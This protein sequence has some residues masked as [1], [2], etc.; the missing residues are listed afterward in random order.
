[1]SDTQKMDDFFLETR[2][3]I[4]Q[5]GEIALVLPEGFVSSIILNAM[6]KLY[7]DLLSLISRNELR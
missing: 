5:L 7:K 6:P 3:L 2:T 1:M 4:D